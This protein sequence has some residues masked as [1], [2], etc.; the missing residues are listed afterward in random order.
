MRVLYFI[1]GPIS[2]GPL[3]PQELLRRQSILQKQAGANTEV[4]VRDAESGP[5][6]IE[7]L[8]EEYLSV[9][10]MMQAV[11]D[12]EREGIDAVIAGC[13]GDPGVDGAREIAGIP[14]IGPCESSMHLAAM[15]GYKFSVVTVLDEVKPIIRKVLHHT[16]L[17]SRM[18]SVRVI[19]TSVLDIAGR[20]SAVFNRLVDAGR[21]AIDQDGADTL[22]LG[23]MSLA[24][25]ELSLELGD[26]LGVPVISPAEAAL[27]TAETLVSLK[28]SQR[29]KAYGTPIKMRHL[30]TA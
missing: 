12:A 14:V 30:Q 23:C 4:L 17:E 29:K 27:K 11:A 26:V 24:F 22:I 19:E 8:Y 5:S 20:R 28:L 6:S 16:G 1:P 13:F 10:G 21:L 7:S 18:A 15:L 25:Q 3:G 2:K 9:P